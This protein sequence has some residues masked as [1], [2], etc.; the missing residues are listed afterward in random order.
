MDKI[1]R[2]QIAG[3][4][5]IIFALMQLPGFFTGSPPE[6]GDPLAEFLDF[7]SDNR[8]LLMVAGTLGGLT[9]LPFTALLVG[10]VQLLRDRAGQFGLAPLI[11]LVAGAV[12]AAT[13]GAGQSLGLAAAYLV[14]S[15]PA[16]ET[17]TLH[18]MSGLA[19]TQTMTAAFAF[20]VASGY[21]LARFGRG[22]ERY[23]G[24]LGAVAAALTLLA[25]FTVA[26]SGYF[27]VGGLGLFVGFG[28]M[29]TYL[30]VLSILLLVSRADAGASAGATG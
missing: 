2:R 21:S 27:G 19:Y 25:S 22:G 4:A 8:D 15:P 13:A 5:G 11:A 29:L 28:A 9:V 3:A 7:Y 26:D 1:T 24:W 16:A 10:V 14:D 20:A 30:V 23:V 6:A 18:I 17:K 12:A